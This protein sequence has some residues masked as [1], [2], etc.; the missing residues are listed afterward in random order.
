[1]QKDEILDLVND[2]DEVI[3]SMERGE[4]YKRGLSNFRG[5]NCFIINSKGELWIP[6]RQH[7]KRIFPNSLDVSCGGHVSSGETSKEAFKKEMQEELNINI[8]TVKYKVLGKCNPKD[9]NVSAFM[10]VYELV[11]DVAPEYNKDDFQSYEWITPKDLLQ[12]IQAGAQSKG[13]LPKLV[14]KFYL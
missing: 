4:V 10:T 3:D 5:I 8:D 9:D 13:D 2:S 1:M 7:N 11:Q 12:K 6:L 14:K